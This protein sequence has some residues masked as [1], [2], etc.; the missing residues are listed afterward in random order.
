M[1]RPADKESQKQAT[2]H[3]AILEGFTRVGNVVS[4]IVSYSS[5]GQPPIS[6]KD[7]LIHSSTVSLTKSL[8]Q[9]ELNGALLTDSESDIG[10]SMF[11]PIETSSTSPI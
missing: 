11:K 4:N 6:K 2:S 9:I 8:A 10:N 5:Q 7:N 1:P 3:I